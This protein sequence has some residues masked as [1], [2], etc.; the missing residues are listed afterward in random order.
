M[1]EFSSFFKLNE[2]KLPKE[3]S[4]VRTCK[5]LTIQ[6]K[7]NWKQTNEQTSKKTSDSIIAT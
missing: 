1:Y 6:L 7:K 3:K 4:L 5:N 2:F